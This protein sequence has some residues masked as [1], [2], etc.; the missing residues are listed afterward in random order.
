[1]LKLFIFL[2]FL[3][4][5]GYIIMSGSKWNPNSWKNKVIY[6]DVKYNDINLVKKNEDKLKNVFPLIYAGEA[7]KLKDEIIKAQNGKGIVLMGGDCAESFSEHNISHYISSFR[8]LLQMT[9]IFMNNLG[10]PVIKIGRMAGQ[11]AKPRSNLFEDYNNITVPTYR[12]DIINSYKLDEFSR[13]YDPNKM[14]EAYYSSCQT[15]NLIRCLSQGG[16][17]DIERIDKWNLEFINSENEMK[18]KNLSNSVK[19]SLNLIKATG[20]K[21][22]YFF[23]KASFYTAHEALLLNYEAPLTRM[24]SISKKYYGCSGH[25]LWVGERTRQLDGAHIEYMS[26]IAN[27]IGIKIS[28]KCEP[29]EL[30]KLIEKLNPN[31]EPGKLSLIIRMGRNLWSKLPDLIEIVNNNNKI[32]TWITD[33][34][35]GNTRTLSNGIKT[36]KMDDILLEVKTF[37]TILKLNNAKFGGIHLEMTGENVT[38]CLDFSSMENKLN[39]EDNYNTLCDPRLNADQCL[40]LAFELCDFLDLN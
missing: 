17:A 12:G 27:P 6:Q 4:V 19:K 20:L 31:N 33:P 30:L 11:Y 35:H 39:I 21:D 24:D 32:V 36:R 37:I 9:L 22:N 10:L 13:T 5:N 15:M 14:L 23:E 26:G 29:S 1:M 16:Y 8:I 38:E 18:Y 25:M 28:E 3:V 40:Q 2:C 34:M 7:E